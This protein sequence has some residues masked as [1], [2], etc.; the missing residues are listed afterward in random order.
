MRN[1]H[2]YS[3]K[4]ASLR[5][6]AR[7]ELSNEVLLAK[8][9]SVFAEAQHKS[10]SAR[11]SMIPTISVVDALR[12][13]GWKPVSARE[14]T[15]RNA[16]RKG[17]QKHEIRFALST[18]LK[19]DDLRVGDS[20]IEVVMTNS[21]DGSSAYQMQ[22][23]IYRPVCS[24][25]MIVCES[26]FSKVSVRHVD[27]D[28]QEIIDVT[29][30]VVESAPTIGAQVDKFRGTQLEEP[31][32]EAFAKEALVLRCGLESP[33]EIA[34]KAP[35]EASALLTPKRREDTGNDLWSTLNVIQENV[36]RGGQKDWRKRKANGKR[37]AKTRAVKGIDQ[38]QKLNK[39]L[40]RIAE[41]IG[42]QLN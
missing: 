41:V 11:Y 27:L 36:I 6:T 2:Y 38:D 42:Q 24:N 21:H 5:G 19:G 20:L 25:G 28:P 4:G 3:P 12:D 10:R 26:M 31:I 39:A 23:G 17:F 13:A 32:R 34:E 18:S 8:A 1:L 9:P 35:I 7:Q 30:E 29:A 16:T 15:V 22:A 33:D 14:Q 40:F 37:F